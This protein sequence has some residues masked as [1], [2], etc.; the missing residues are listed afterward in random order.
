M[1]ALRPDR[2]G[3]RAPAADLRQRHEAFRGPLQRDGGT[4][5]RALA[6][7]L[8]FD[9]YS[10]MFRSLQFAESAGAVSSRSSQMELRL[11][12][13]L[14]ASLAPALQQ[15]A[16]DPVKQI[17]VRREVRPFWGGER[18]GE[19]TVARL[20]AEGLDRAG[21]GAA[22]VP[23]LRRALRRDA[24]EVGA[25]H[26][27]RPAALPGARAANCAAACAATSRG[28]RPTARC[29]SAPPGAKSLYEAE[30]LP[31]LRRLRASLARAE[32]LPRPHPSR[33]GGRPLARADA[34]LPLPQHAGL[35]ARPAVPPHPRR[36]APLPALQPAGGR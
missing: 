35:R 9:L 6:A 22:A 19:R 15:V 11:L 29:A 12:E 17:S 20:A 21:R 27:P 13:R 16:A 18:L 24:A 36:G 3:R 4:A 5:A 10:K 14:W 7:G 26:H 30:D 28:S 25:R 32:A 2:R 33:P 8:V 1:A 31:R 34:A 23:R